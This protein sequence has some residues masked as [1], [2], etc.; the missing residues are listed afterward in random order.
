MVVPQTSQTALVAFLPFFMVTAWA[1]LP[2]LLVLHLTQ[3]IAI[4]N[5]PL[6]NFVPSIALFVG[7]NEP[8]VVLPP[9]PENNFRFKLL[10]YAVKLA[11]F[12]AEIGD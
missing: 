5:H 7:S 12:T 4:S 3:Y 6:S 11:F 8:G 10:F 2:S 1:S 9:E